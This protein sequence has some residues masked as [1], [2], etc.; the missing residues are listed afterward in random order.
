MLPPTPRTSPFSYSSLHHASWTW[1]N[2]LGTHLKRNSKGHR[3]GEGGTAT[4]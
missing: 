3:V 4:T 1:A 2:F